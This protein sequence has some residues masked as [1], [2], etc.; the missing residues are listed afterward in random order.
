MTEFS[1]RVKNYYFMLLLCSVSKYKY[2]HKKFHIVAMSLIKINTKTNVT[3]T[4][5]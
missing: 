5:T 4:K 2:Q 3:L 1:H